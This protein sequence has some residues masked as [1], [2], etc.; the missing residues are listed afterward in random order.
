MRLGLQ[1]YDRFEIAHLKG[2]SVARTRN[3]LYRGLA[4]LRALLTAQ[5][6]SPVRAQRAPTRISRD[7][8]IATASMI[9]KVL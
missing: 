7:E 8:T 2:W 1:G 4:D 6:I 3:L 9:A 5:G